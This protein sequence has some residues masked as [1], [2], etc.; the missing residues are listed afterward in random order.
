MLVV[1]SADFGT[2]SVPLLD[3]R[4]QY[5]TIRAEVMEAVGRVFESQHFILG[6]EV[7]R[8]EQELAEYCQAGYAVGCGS[9][10][11]ALFLALLALDI[12]PGDEVATT[13]FT[14][15]ATAGAIVRAGARP[16]FVDIERDSF[17][18]D[19]EKLKETLARR[20][21]IRAVIPI[22]LFGAC[23]DVDA[24]ST[25]CD[26]AGA[27]VIEDA[28]QAIGSE[29]RS[30]RAGSMGRI[31]CFSFFPTKNLGGA[32]EGG[33]LTTQDRALAERLSSLRVHGS[34]VRYF[35]DEV[36]VN[37]RL[38]ALQAAVLRVKLKHLDAWTAARQANARRYW[39]RLGELRLPVVLPAPPEGTTR[40]VYNQFVIRAERRDDLK[41][42]LKEQG[43]GTEIYYPLPLHVQK[44]FA[45]LGYREGDFPVSEEA[46]REV[47]A[48]PI[49]SE[50]PADDLDYVCDRIVAFYRGKA[51]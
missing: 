11:D 3:L 5:E 15:F 21:G 43:V 22:H 4:A 14:F 19:P 25:A 39:E 40:H 2:K 32:G 26:A 6:E 37:S 27:T 18:I 10:S 50:L 44:C 31:G 45:D 24:I 42:F 17:N 48:L 7:E 33:L 36:G 30:R 41:T 13:P 9:G 16:V 46:A 38:D 34:R 12:G 51:G 47:L 28:A 29:Y 49:Y 23:A 20:P 8:L 35:H 1:N